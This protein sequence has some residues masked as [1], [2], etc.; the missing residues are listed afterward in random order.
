MSK[1]VWSVA[2]SSFESTSKGQ[3]RMRILGVISSFQKLDYG[4]EGRE[5][6]WN[7]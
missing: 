7:E 4:R 3:G 6:L 5:R 1:F 2:L